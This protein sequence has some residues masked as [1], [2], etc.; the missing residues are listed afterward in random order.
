MCVAESLRE[1][2]EFLHGLRDLHQA[3]WT[4]RGHAGAFATDFYSRFH[5]NLV[6]KLF[7]TGEIQLLRVRAGDHPIG[8]LYNL[9]K[10]GK[11]HAYQSGFTFDP[12]SRLK[13]GLV[14]HSLAIDY[15]MQT[16]ASVYDFMAGASQYKISLGT[17]SDRMFW[18]VVYRKRMKLRLENS[19]RRIKAK[20][21]NR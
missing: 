8:Y 21:I 5:E 7:D 17:H 12:D 3:S 9:R 4:G 1:A 2:L 15:N 11:V 6:S 19:L 10:G 20:I 18:P 16:G 13:P 14:S